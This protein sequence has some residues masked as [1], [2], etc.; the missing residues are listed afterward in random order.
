MN[1][2]ER[3]FNL[4]PLPARHET[5]RRDSFL[6]ILGGL[7]VALALWGFQTHTSGYVV[8]MLTVAGL[9]AVLAVSYNLI[10]GVTGQLSLE[11]NAFVACGAYVTALLTLS[12]AEKAASF[13]LEPLIWPFAVF[14]IPLLPALIVAGLVTAFMAFIMGFPVFRVRGD[15][16]AIVT[17]GFGEVIRVVA[18][19]AQTVTNGPL[20]L[21]GIPLITNLWWAWGLLALT[22][23]VIV[24]LVNSSYGR[25]LKA[26]REDETAA[27]AMGINAFWHK[28]L[29][30]TLSAFFEGVAGG[31]LAHLITTISP[32]LFTFFLTFNL[33]II[34]VVGGLGSTTG[35]V[36]ATLLFTFGGEWLR[37]VEEPF[38][39]LSWQ[40]PGI[41]GMRMVIFSLILIAVMIFMRKGFLGRNEFTW[42]WLLA[43]LAR[44]QP[45]PPPAEG[46]ASAWEGG[47][48]R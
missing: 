33:L 14:S 32:T 26:I 16:L 13:I 48:G 4:G 38:Q 11:P 45:P 1:L 15:Y 18:N 39:L 24:R 17:L 37:V 35:A 42:R 40:I 25:A 27:E 8:H 29:A 34:I 10:N 19:N 22:L 2:R 12:P 20:G 43:A 6:T 30:F 28:M 44:R 3:V 36:L 21:K 41:P 46:G 9:Y 7:T 5:R 23:F 31:L 47:H